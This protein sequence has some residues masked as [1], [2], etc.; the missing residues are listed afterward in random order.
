MIVD[1]N[2]FEEKSLAAQEKIIR[3]F[4]IEKPKKP[5]AKAWIANEL[6]RKKTKSG[7]SEM[8]LRK[9]IRELLRENDSRSLELAAT[10]H[11]LSLEGAGHIVGTVVA[12]DTKNG[13]LFIVNVTGLTPGEHGLHIHEN[14][15]LG[16]G[17]KDG[18]MKVGLA[19]GGHFDPMQTKKH[20][21]P[22]GN[23]HLGDLPKVY[24]DSDG[25]VKAQVLA[26]RIKALD[27]AG[28]PIIIHSGG[29]NYF[30]EPDEMGGGKER[31]IGGILGIV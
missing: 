1:G 24:A 27:V 10:L 16:P 29:D 19:A 28:R 26:P 8:F 25:T 14:P 30:Y 22:Y 3:K 6:Q 18:I 7:M 17:L 20:L 4:L 12:K 23:G 21:G 13:L 15:D 9:Y 2:D 31:V 5:E 11:H